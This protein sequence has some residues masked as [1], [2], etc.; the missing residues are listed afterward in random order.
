M[1][2]AAASGGRY[3]AP[4]TNRRSSA[5][6]PVAVAGALMLLGACDRAGDSS[7][8]SRSGLAGS[9]TSE[10]GGSEAFPAFCSAATGKAACATTDEV[11]SFWGDRPLVDSSAWN[12]TWLL[13]EGRDAAAGQGDVVVSVLFEGDAP[14]TVEE[15]F[16]LSYPVVQQTI[17]TDRGPDGRRLADVPEDVDGSDGSTKRWIDVGGRR[18]LH[19]ATSEIDQLQFVERF[20]GDLGVYV[21]VTLASG[22]FATLRRL[23]ESLEPVT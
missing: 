13:E 3:G 14:A 7:P 17:V 16:D 20:E 12:R 1:A 9:P 18:M 11:V 15:A 8:P 5:A 4:M 19:F 23:A 2:A 22:R 6:V 21:E 10:R